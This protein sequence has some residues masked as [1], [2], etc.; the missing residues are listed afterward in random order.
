[1]RPV[2]PKCSGL[3]L[4]EP[5][6]EGYEDRVLCRVC[7][8]Q[9]FRAPQ[10]IQTEKPMEQKISYERKCIDCGIVANHFGNRCGPCWADFNRSR[11]DTDNTYMS[12]D[13]QNGCDDTNQ[14]EEVI[15]TTKTTQTSGTP[16]GYCPSCNRDDVLMPGPKCS[17]CYDRIK[18]GKDVITGEPV[19]AETPVQDKTTLPPVATADRIGDHVERVGEAVQKFI[20]AAPPNKKRVKASYVFPEEVTLSFLSAR[21][22]DL[23]T[24]LMMEADTDRRPLDCQIMHI[25][26]MRYVDKVVPH[27]H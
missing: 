16:R 13:I 14:I 26:E 10:V 22:A 25:L 17:R 4:F 2:C 23:L 3:L 11:N 24:Q 12:N 7:G 6:A 20:E 8:W 15:V 1:M 21:D 27:E 19:T 9:V 18:K 5:A